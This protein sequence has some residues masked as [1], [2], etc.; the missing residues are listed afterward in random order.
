MANIFSGTT[1]I[2]AIAKRLRVIDPHTGI[3]NLGIFLHHH[4]LRAV[5]DYGSC[6][7][8]DTFPSTEYPFKYFTS[9]D[10]ATL[11]EKA[12][13]SASALKLTRIDRVPIHR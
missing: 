11:T 8:P 1:N 6:H 10:N 2:I 4:Q 3:H 5:R 12:D 13:R 9:Q 7:D